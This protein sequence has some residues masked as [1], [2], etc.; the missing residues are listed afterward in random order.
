MAH[1]PTQKRVRTAKITGWEVEASPF[2]NPCNSTT[3]CN[4]M[5]CLS[6]PQQW[7]SANYQKLRM[8]NSRLI[9]VVSWLTQVKKGQ[10]HTT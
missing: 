7:L 10:C 4:G 6:M 5:I 9:A 2:I 1:A 8:P 3:T